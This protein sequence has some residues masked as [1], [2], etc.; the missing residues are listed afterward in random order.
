MGVPVHTAA[1]LIAA[2]A[3]VLLAAA[4]AAGW[5]R[6]RRRAEGLRREK[7]EQAG[8]LEATERARA[9][10]VERCKD[11]EQKLSISDECLIMTEAKVAKL[12]D[13]VKML[14]ARHQENDEWARPLRGAL[15]EAV[16]HKMRELAARLQQQAQAIAERDRVHQLMKARLAQVEGARARA[17]AELAAK[18]KLLSDL[19]DR[20]AQ[21]ESREA[22]RA[23]GIRLDVDGATAV[24]AA[25]NVPSNPGALMPDEAAAAPPDTERWVRAMH[26]SSREEQL[27]VLLGW[28]ERLERRLSDLENLQVRLHRVYSRVPDAKDG[29]AA[30]P[31]G[32]STRGGSL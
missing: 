28:Q 15:G 2:A 9:L 1:W 23:A 3:C 18:E 29:E 14:V 7:E 11:L 27:E 6:A 22:R 17:A 16:G 26:G 10:T 19:S 25:M 8:R 21:L 4:C 20:V 24:P 12:E 32:R 30:A 5:L 31:E 13:R